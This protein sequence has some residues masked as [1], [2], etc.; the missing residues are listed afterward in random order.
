VPQDHC[1]ERV[2]SL[3]ISRGVAIPSL[4]F[5]GE[6]HW[7]VSASNLLKIV[8]VVVRSSHLCKSAISA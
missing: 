7:L 6:V 1:R 4:K 3:F 2:P 8:G 5:D